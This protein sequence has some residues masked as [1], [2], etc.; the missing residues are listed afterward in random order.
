MSAELPEWARPDSRA[1]TP[2]AEFREHYAV[3]DNLWWRTACGHHQNLFEDACEH[4]DSARERAEQLEAH[5]THLNDTVARVLA[6]HD[7][8]TCAD[9]EGRDE[10][11]GLFTCPTLAAIRGEGPAPTPPPVNPLAAHLDRLKLDWRPG[12]LP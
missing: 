7:G 5:V 2:L 4:L 6:I 10:E 1:P 12:E 9:R 11:T 8:R 3:D